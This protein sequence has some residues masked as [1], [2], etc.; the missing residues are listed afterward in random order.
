M[1]SSSTELV[2]TSRSKNS[3]SSSR[4]NSSE[5]ERIMSQK[6]LR[7]SDPSTT[8]EDTEED[9]EGSGCKD[10]ESESRSQSQSPQQDKNKVGVLFLAVLVF[11]SVSGGPFGVE[12]SVR[13]AG[14]FYTLLG[15]L[16]APLVWSIPEALLTAELAS[17]FPEA[18]GGMAWVE[19][20]FGVEVGW[21]AG[22]LGWVAGATDN[23]IYPVLFLDYLVQVLVHGH[24]GAAT[25]NV[26]TDAPDIDS[27][28]T[29]EEHFLVT[30]PVARFLFLA[31]ASIAL[32]FVNWLGLPIVGRMSV[33]ICCLA[34]SPFVIL[35]VVGAFQVDPARWLQGPPAPVIGTD[36]DTDTDS[37]LP[38]AL[39]FGGLAIRPWLNNLFWNFNSFDAAS[40]FAEDVVDPGRVFPRAMFWSVLMVFSSYM[41]PLLVALGASDA[42][43]VEWVDGYL[44]TVA[45]E[46]VGPWLG[47]WT[48]F[49]AGISNI[50]LFQ[51]ELSA[52]SFQLMG[53]AERGHVPAIFAHRSRHGT[54]TWSIVL[55]TTFIVVLGAANL[56]RLIEMLNFNYSISLLLEYLAFIKLRV[57]R[58]DLHRPWRVPLGTVGCALV[59]LPSVAFTLAVILMASS[60]TYIFCILVNLVGVLLCL[61]RKRGLWGAGPTKAYDPITVSD[62]GALSSE[63]ELS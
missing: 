63:H 58:P 53:M 16:L 49:A 34:M 45:I 19:E 42:E 57:T 2:E 50:G 37:M 60:S 61:A 40:S 15:F 27:S 47:A 24:T 51:A 46:I 9:D 48:V 29:T 62:D 32:G 59:F 30:N 43:P 6:A 38:Y 22:Y 10:G 4:S 1:F 3:N 12:A 35:T 21:M 33:A 26:N 44:S 17:T 5:H 41:F 7:S 31:C 28:D 11:Y 20:A 55:G 18:A 13:S 52:D 36:D 8:Y 25:L 39:A 56:D 23:A 14:H 54:P